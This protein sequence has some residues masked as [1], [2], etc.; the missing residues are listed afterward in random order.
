M[1]EKG[2]ISIKKHERRG[3]YFQGC[4]IKTDV[5]SHMLLYKMINLLKVKIK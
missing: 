1:A 4:E 5:S 2:L 3:W